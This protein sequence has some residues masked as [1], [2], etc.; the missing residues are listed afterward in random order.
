MVSGVP[1]VSPGGE[2]LGNRATTA[3]QHA[4]STNQAGSEEHEAVGL[5]R[6]RHET[7]DGRRAGCLSGWSGRGRNQEVAANWLLDG[8]SAWA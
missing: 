4:S 6:S 1:S 5:R 8:V 7:L 3:H 2:K